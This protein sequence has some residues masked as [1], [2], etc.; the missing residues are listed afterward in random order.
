VI[1]KIE[2]AVQS[3]AIQIKSNRFSRNRTDFRQEAQ[4]AEKTEQDTY[5]AKSGKQEG[6]C[7]ACG[8]NAKTG[9]IAAE[10]ERLE[11]KGHSRVFG[12]SKKGLWPDG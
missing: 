1:A 7:R 4:S 2:N 10:K 6:K 3:V 5:E 8:R 12:K 9:K 11:N